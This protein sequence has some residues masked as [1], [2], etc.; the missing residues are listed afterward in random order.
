MKIKQI[1]KLAMQSFKKGNLDP[2]KIKKIAPLL[3]RRQ[4]KTYIRFIKKLDREKKVLVFTPIDKVDQKT[5]S[6]LRGMFPEK[7]IEYI[8]RSDLIAGIRIVDNDIVYEFNVK[9]SLKSLASYIKQS[10]D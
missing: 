6:K 5:T 3:N 1:K 2:E 9:D 7:K 4:L 10:Y 8:K